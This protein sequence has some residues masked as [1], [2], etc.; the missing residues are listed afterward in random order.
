MTQGAPPR[1]LA[2]A[3]DVGTTVP[4]IRPGVLWRSDAPYA[5][6]DGPP[7]ASAWPP[8]TVID[9]RDS[10]ERGVLHPYGDS[11]T[12]MWVPLIADASPVHVSTVP[13]LGDLYLG[14]LAQG[15]AQLLVSVI[16]TVATAEGSVLVH[17]AAGKDRTGVSVA[18]ALSLT[19]TRRDHIIE[20]YLLT[21]ANMPAV[22]ER[23]MAPGSAHQGVV[24]DSSRF[25]PEMLTAS[26]VAIETV[27]DAWG[28]AGGAEE[29]FLAAG[30][31]RETIT[32]LRARLSA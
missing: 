8:G 32:A 4:G 5:P 1:G 20:D 19:G 28:A 16:D 27:L 9:L 3:R 29:W 21:A 2:N 10:R 25:P 14:M 15:P 12:V 24:F 23:L 13:T 22:L 30:G 26:L 7:G 6:H 18:L 31:S 17:C 11:A